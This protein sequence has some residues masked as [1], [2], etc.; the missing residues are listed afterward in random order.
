M[1]KWIKSLFLSYIS[2]IFICL[3]FDLNIKENFFFRMRYLK[4]N[5]EE[6]NFLLLSFTA[7]SILILVFLLLYKLF[8]KLIYKFYY[9][10]KIIFNNVLFVFS[11][12]FTFVCF[13]IINDIFQYYLNIYINNYELI[14]F[15][16]FCIYF[17]NKVFFYIL[18]KEY[19]I[20]C[21]I[22]QIESN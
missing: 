5:L 8:M 15:I 12:F 18:N 13:F 3:C 16:I 20:S 1:F 14:L 10:K 2:C 17:L 11:N 4:N 21:S 9:K 22:K 19:I 6:F 7:S